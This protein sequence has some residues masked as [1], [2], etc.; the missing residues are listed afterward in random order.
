MNQWINYH[1]LFFLSRL[2]QKKELCQKRPRNY[3]WVN[4]LSLPSLS[5]LKRRLGVQLFERHHKKLILTE[6]GKVALDYY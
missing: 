4:P 6:Q 5:S 3:S 1:H 2:L